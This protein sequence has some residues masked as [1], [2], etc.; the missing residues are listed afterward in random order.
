MD[1]ISVRCAGLVVHQATVTAC[2]RLPGPPGECTHVIW[3]FGTTTPNL[4][5]LRDWLGAHGVTHV[6]IESMGVYWKPVYYMTKM[7]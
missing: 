3:P 2:V 6:A 1:F 5:T 7:A 4:L